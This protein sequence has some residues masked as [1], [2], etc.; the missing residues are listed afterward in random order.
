MK[1]ITI[2]SVLIS[3]NRQRTSISG[4][5]DL[6][7]S[8]EKNGLLHA[9][10]LEDD[11][12]TLRAGERRF[13]AISRLAEQGKSFF[14][15]GEVVPPGHMP[16]TS[17]RDLDEAA[18]YEVELEE[19]IQRA[20]LPWQ[21]RLRAM[22][23]LRQLHEL[24]AG[25]PLSTAEFAR[26]VVG[27]D[28]PTGGFEFRA[29]HVA[30]IA[31][32]LDDPD[33]A[34]AKTQKEALNIIRRKNSQVLLEELNRRMSD[35]NMTPGTCPHTLIRGSAFDEVPKLP[36][37]HFS[38]ILTDPPYGIGMDTMNTQSGS[39][40]ALTHTYTDSYEYAKS[41]TTLV[42]TEGFRVTTASAVCYMFCDVRFFT[43][44]Q[45]IFE[46]AGWYVWPNPIIWNKTPVGSLLGKANGP[47]HCYETILMAIKGDRGV[48]TVG[49]DVIS[50]APRADKDHPAEKPVELLAHILGWSA[51]PGDNILDMFAGSCNIIPAAGQKQCAVTCIEKDAQYW[52]LGESK[53]LGSL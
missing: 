30:K 42:A 6:A 32:Y 35:A 31:P 41:C 11:G 28:V 9:P 18:L 47:R 45:Q 2:N 38:V 1:L 53:L 44:W 23:R 16:Y 17:L 20:E 37:N 22:E 49:N 51:I 40:S 21:D 25:T 46:Q 10:V 19:N 29:Q 3:K 43:D 4:I 8:I 24:R 39:A 13:R 27:P 34:K 5:D 12:V 33:V 14:Y 15:D 50:F 48:N 52:P 7:L 36:S 26:Q